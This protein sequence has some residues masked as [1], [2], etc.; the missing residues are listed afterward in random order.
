M[1][2]KKINKLTTFC[3]I[4]GIL[5]L[6]V[7]F[8]FS[9][10]TDAVAYLRIGQYYADANFDLAIN[11]YWGPLFSWLLVP[12]LKIGIPP[13][14]S[15][16]ILMALSAILFYF[17]CDYFFKRSNLREEWG[18]AGRLTAGFASL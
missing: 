16:R 6:G 4:A 12:F 18:A 11:G 1:N 10:N 7:I 15:A 3:L 8:R 17:A 13:L 9:M 14:I 5:I 2:Y